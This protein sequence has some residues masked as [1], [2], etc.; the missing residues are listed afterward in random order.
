MYFAGIHATKVFVN[1]LKQ[2]Y[3]KNDIIILFIAMHVTYYR[4]LWG[5][6]NSNHQMYLV[7]PQYSS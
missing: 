4:L 7:L 1:Q 5:Y 6:I 3:F 2:V